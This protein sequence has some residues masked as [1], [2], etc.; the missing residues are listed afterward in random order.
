MAKFCAVRLYFPSW[1]DCTLS[2]CCLMTSS[3]L[4]HRAVLS[5]DLLWYATPA[6]CVMIAFHAKKHLLIVVAASMDCHLDILVFCSIVLSLFQHIAIVGF[7]FYCPSLN[8]PRSMCRRDNVLAQSCVYLLGQVW[9]LSSFEVSCQLS[10]NDLKQVL[11][12]SLF[13]TS[14]TA[15]A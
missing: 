2:Q 4:L 13:M 8:C 9:S 7:S 6:Q 5:Q 10:T 12:V 1:I 15:L 11:S 3:L 14:S